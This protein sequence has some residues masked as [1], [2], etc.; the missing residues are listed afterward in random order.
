MVRQLGCPT[1]FLTLSAAEVRWDELIVILRKVKTGED[2]SL[3]QAQAMSY[4]DKAEL[5]RNDPVTCAI[6]FDHKIRAIFCLLSKVG[7]P[8]GAY[9]IIDSYIRVEFQHR[10]SPHVHCLLWIRNAPKYNSEDPQSKEQCI[11]FIDQLTTCSRS[12]LSPDNAHLA[13]YQ[14]H[15][16]TKCCERQKGRRKVCRFNFPIPPMSR[17]MILDPIRPRDR[18]EEQKAHLRTIN[19]LLLDLFRQ[20][21]PITLS[22]DD[23]LRR[24]NLTE[25]QYI[26]AIRC[27]IKTAKVFL[28][29]TPAE[30]KINAFN[31]AILQLHRANMDIQFVLDPYSCAA[32]ILNYINKA[33]KGMSKLLR[34]IV[35]ETRRGNST[36][37]E[38]LRLICNKFLNSS[39]ISAQEAVYYIL[40]LS[41]SHA[42]RKV[43]FINTSLPQRRDRMLRPREQLEELDENDANIF[44]DNYLNYYA[45][46]DRHLE[47]EC[48]ASVVANYEV[49]KTPARV[50]QRRPRENPED[51]ANSDDE[52]EG[53]FFPI[54]HTRLSHRKR[55][56]SKVIR[57][58]RFRVD[59]EPAD[60]YREQLMLFLPWRDEQRDLIDIL[61]HDVYQNNLREIKANKEP[62]SPLDNEQVMEMVQQHMQ[63]VEDEE[64]DRVEIEESQPNDRLPNEFHVFYPRDSQAEPDIFQQMG[65]EVARDR[66]VRFTA[67]GQLDGAEYVEKVARLNDDQ[68]KL[69]LE[70][71]HLA[72]RSEEPY[73]IFVSGGAGVGKSAFIETLCFVLN[74]YY[75]R[76][77]GNNADTAKILLCAPTGRAAFNIKG[78]TIHSTFLLPLSQYGGPLPRLGDSVMNT[79][80][81][82]FRD[83]E[84]II[85]DEVSMVGGKLFNHMNTR[86]N[87]IFNT[88]NEVPF[89]NKSVIM[90]GDLKQLCPVGDT[91]AQCVFNFFRLTNVIF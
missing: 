23:F 90:V 18:T 67:P 75:S 54:A 45:N 70:I 39:E 63:N 11:E 55:T 47:R 60:Y 38:R 52:M 76:L 56:K 51:S 57:Y 4:A 3:E 40:G 83:I 37:K 12:S 46:R 77:P 8:L 26:E 34:R 87:Q 80:R 20:R 42:S 58:P 17:T 43:V 85:V 28:K 9:L 30:I 24:L 66:M 5:I 71:L 1:L 73:H 81:S 48:L 15:K 2:I 25:A 62:F 21:E 29:R 19:A 31:P 79:V 74:K 68:R 50:T 10:G 13:D 89:G 84:L 32:Y 82:N 86:C 7:S 91:Y 61:H 53:G 49:V 6:Y 36:L 27:T 88:G 65:L 72:A 16:H 14:V 41:V 44:L 22:F 59:K 78:S 64:N 69:V 35:E 33:N